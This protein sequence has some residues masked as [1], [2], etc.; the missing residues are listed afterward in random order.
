MDALREEIR[1]LREASAS[2]I[3]ALREA[4]GIG[5]HRARELASLRE[6]LSSASKTAVNA[7]PNFAKRWTDGAANR[8]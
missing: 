3:S 6:A 1:A 4:L 7:T 5:E 8:W 2:K